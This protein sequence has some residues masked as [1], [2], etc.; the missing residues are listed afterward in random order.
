VEQYPLEF[1]KYDDG[2]EIPIGGFSPP[3]KSQ[4]RDPVSEPF[5]ARRVRFLVAEHALNH[6]THIS[7]TGCIVRG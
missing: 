5:F 4:S 1:V 3:C 7:R 6:V 2:S